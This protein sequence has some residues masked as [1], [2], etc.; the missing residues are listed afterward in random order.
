M[1]APPLLD[2]ILEQHRLARQSPADRDIGLELQLQPFIL[3]CAQAGWLENNDRNHSGVVD[4]MAESGE[5][6]IGGF[7]CLTHQAHGHH[8]PAA[9]A[10]LG[11]LYLVAKS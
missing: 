6:S 10:A 2:E 7:D 3:D 4:H 5:G 8:R 1:I 11:K 9:A